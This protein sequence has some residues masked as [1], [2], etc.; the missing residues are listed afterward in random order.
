[1]TLWWVTLANHNVTHVQRNKKNI[2]KEKEERHLRHCGWPMSQCHQ[3]QCH[4]NATR[5]CNTYDSYAIFHKGNILL[6]FG[7]EKMV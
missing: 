6:N 1:V 4:P 5:K 2:V 7:N 3:P